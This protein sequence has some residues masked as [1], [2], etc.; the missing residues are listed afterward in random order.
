MA[1]TQKSNQPKTIEVI[2]LRA[3]RIP[4]REVNGDETV[5]T[6]H[7]VVEVDE[8]VTLDTPTAR[9]VIASNK[10][11]E[12]REKADVAAARARLEQR[13]KEAVEKTKSAS[14]QNKAA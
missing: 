11:I 3:F 1:V 10:A 8:V 5:I 6:G 2:A 9:D 13:R 7:R 14:E 12:A 4:E